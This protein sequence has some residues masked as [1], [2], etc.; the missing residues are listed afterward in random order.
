VGKGGGQHEWCNT[1][2]QEAWQHV[3]TKSPR[4][5]YRVGFKADRDVGVN[6]SCVLAKDEEGVPGASS[7]TEGEDGAGGGGVGGWWGGREKRIHHK[8]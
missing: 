1:R 2:G 4:W 6:P 3:A 5:P 8:N 7:T